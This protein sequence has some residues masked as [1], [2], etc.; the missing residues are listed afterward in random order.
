MI[1]Y[2][3]DTV[4]L[5]DK[6]KLSNACKS[7]QREFIVGKL[8][9]MEKFMKYEGHPINSGNF[10]IIRRLIRLA[11]QNYIVSIAKHVAHKIHYPK[12]ISGQQLSVAKQP[13]NVSK[14]PMT[15]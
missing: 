5:Q 13:K 11:Y 3:L 6:N 2:D 9:A 10:F 12:F 15:R 8:S 1:E 7:F 4:K 14:K